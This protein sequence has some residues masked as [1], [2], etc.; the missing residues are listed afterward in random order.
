MIA[1]PN[2]RFPIGHEPELFHGRGVSA[3]WVAPS[4]GVASSKLVQQIHHPRV[5]RIEMLGDAQE[6]QIGSIVEDGAADGNADSTPE[7]AH[8]RKQPA[9]QLQAFWW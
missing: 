2:L 5:C 7:A 6:V 8:Q 3:D 9:C 1:S 4:L